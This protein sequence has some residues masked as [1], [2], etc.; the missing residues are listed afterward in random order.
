MLCH[1]H[2]SND[3][4]RMDLHEDAE[5]NIVTAS[6][7]FPGVSKEGINIL[8]QNNR[9]TVSAE[10]KQSTEHNEDG[11]AIR[12]RAFGKYSRTLQLPEGIKVSFLSSTK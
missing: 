12:E 8:V 2:A 10:T 7:E 1:A 5:K 4:R 3:V 9:L 6:F 11:Y